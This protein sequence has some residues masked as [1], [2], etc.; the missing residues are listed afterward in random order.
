MDGQ[1]VEWMTDSGEKW[2]RVVCEDS[3]FTTFSI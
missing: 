1:T 2:E 3:G